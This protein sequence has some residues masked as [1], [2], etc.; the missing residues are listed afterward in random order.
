MAQDKNDN[1]QEAPEKDK[2]LEAIN[3]FQQSCLDLAEQVN[4]RLFEGCRSPYWV[5]GVVGGTCDFDGV[6]FLTPEEMV[7]ILMHHMT[8][9]QYS[10]W[11]EANIAHADKDHYINLQS[12]L[13][14]ARYE[15][16]DGKTAVTIPKESNDGSMSLEEM[17]ARL[18][19]AK[20]SFEKALQD[21]TIPIEQRIE[22][23]LQEEP[24]LT[25]SREEL[26]AILS[27][28]QTAADFLA[29]VDGLKN[30]HEDFEQ[31]MSLIKDKVHEFQLRHPQQL[32]T[33]ALYHIEGNPYT[34]Q[35]A[36]GETM[37]CLTNVLNSEQ[38]EQGRANI[39]K[40]LFQN[41]KMSRAFRDIIVGTYLC[42]KK[43]NMVDSM[44][45]TVGERV[46]SASPSKRKRSKK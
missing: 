20:Q 35:P 21:E 19:E 31:L 37:H 1:K 39:I 28:K 42:L 24:D 44:Y 16:F 34:Q 46:T 45:V 15:M 9:E 36:K 8:Y 10:E 38:D 27:D 14:G 40:V 33:L 17:E 25:M 6:D 11:S 26:K 30:L 3:A 41:C 4:E 12:W 23:L 43:A 32:T 5:G 2:A 22:M 18:E 13:M 29:F 7:L